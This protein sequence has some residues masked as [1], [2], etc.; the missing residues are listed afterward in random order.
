[1]AQLIQR[2]RKPLSSKAAVNLTAYGMMAPYM[3]PFLILT[4]IPV[5]T[6]IALS[7]TYF[8][9]LEPPKFIFLEN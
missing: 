1:M 3:I 5:V 6:A 4:I 8:N 7:F 9:M 2:K